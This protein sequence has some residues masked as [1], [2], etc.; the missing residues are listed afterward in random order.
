MPGC[1]VVREV[2]GCSAHYTL[3]GRFDGACAWEL[4]SRL[5]R[6]PLGELV[7][8]FSR[9]GDFVDYAIAVVANGLA[10]LEGKRVQ[11]RGLR[12]HQ[13]RVFKYFG[14]DSQEL[15]R[16]RARTRLDELVDPPALRRE[17]G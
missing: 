9:V 2:R 5:S 12:K 17:V 15:A 6:E 7:L 4:A 8:D 16:P 13:E 1:S 11:L 14:V 3:D 10:G